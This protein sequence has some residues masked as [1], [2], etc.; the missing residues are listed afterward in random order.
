MAV[1]C[2]SRVSFIGYEIKPSPVG[3]RRGLAVSIYFGVAN[4][5]GRHGCCIGVNELP[6][7]CH[8]VPEGRLNLAQDA[9]PGLDL[10]D[11]QSRRD[12]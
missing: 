11:D 8:S 5:A 1:C 3:D 4:W 2:V 7:L 6:T 9:S 12:G 10:T